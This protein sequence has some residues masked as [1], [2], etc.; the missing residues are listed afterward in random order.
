MPTDTLNW[1]NGKNTFYDWK[2]CSL[3]PPSDVLLEKTQVTILVFFVSFFIQLCSAHLLAVYLERAAK[4]VSFHQERSRQR[5]ENISHLRAKKCISQ[6]IMQW[7]RSLFL[8]PFLRHTQTPSITHT[9]RHNTASLGTA[10]KC[11][12]RPSEPCWEDRKQ[13]ANSTVTEAKKPF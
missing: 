8:S 5:D 2:I 12:L 10:C 1:L 4:H 7:E 13:Q 3:F 9:E 6:A 11:V